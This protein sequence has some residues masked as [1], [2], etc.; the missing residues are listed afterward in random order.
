Q[1]G[2]VVV[3]PTDDFSQ[4]V[5]DDAPDPEAIAVARD[6]MQ[7]VIAR[8]GQMPERQQMAIRLYHFENLPLREV[9][10]RLGLSVSRSHDLI[11]EGMEVCDRLRKSGVKDGL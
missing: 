4:T 9:A 10:V 1:R 2:P 7:R 5:V 6:E 11:V 8:I 3:M